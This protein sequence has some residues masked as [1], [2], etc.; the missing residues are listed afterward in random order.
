MA[1]AWVGATC[2]DC[3]REVTGTEGCLGGGRQLRLGRSGRGCSCSQICRR[4]WIRGEGWG[5]GLPKQEL[6]A[7]S[8]LEDQ[9]LVVGLQGHAVFAKNRAVALG[10]PRIRDRACGVLRSGFW[11]DNGFP[12]RHGRCLL[13]VEGGPEWP[14]EASNRPGWTPRSGCRP[15]SCA[16]F[17]RCTSRRGSWGSQ[18]CGSQAC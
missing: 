3:A 14:G 9:L 1:D 7:L 18:G 10:G 5:G 11:F 6:G 17:W 4:E 12:P 16:L 13:P 8:K 2:S 15:C